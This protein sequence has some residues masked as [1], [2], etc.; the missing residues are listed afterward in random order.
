M[1]GVAGE[2]LWPI[3]RC[4]RGAAVVESSPQGSQEDGLDAGG[5]L[6]DL[7][8]QVS[9]LH[10]RQQ[11]GTFVFLRHGA[12]RSDLRGLQQPTSGSLRADRRP[13]R[14]PSGRDGGHGRS[15]GTQRCPTSRRRRSH[16]RTAGC[17]TWS[18]AHRPLLP[19]CGHVA[20]RRHADQGEGQLRVGSSQRVGGDHAGRRRPEP[21]GRGSGRRRGQAPNRP[22]GRLTWL[23]R[24][25][26]RGVRNGDVYGGGAIEWRRQRRSTGA[27]GTAVL[28][29]VGDEGG[30]VALAARRSPTGLLYG[31]RRD[32]QRRSVYGDDL[33]AVTDTARNV[34]SV[35]A[36]TC[37]SE[38]LPRR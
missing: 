10:G 27:S 32:Q 23:N 15:R 3:R 38:R 36:F 21:V 25:V 4:L 12:G 17:S 11:N 28:Q 9:T 26:R 1:T 30:R 22:D 31:P 13:R 8:G 33:S 16:P 14:S 6:L 24:T 37:V 34:L 5:V 20:V 35:D 19:V 18:A 7:D 2:L 29:N